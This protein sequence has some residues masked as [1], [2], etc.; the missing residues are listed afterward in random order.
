MEDFN[1][2]KKEE[3]Q[4]NPNEGMP[5]Q[6]KQYQESRYQDQNDNPYY[7]QQ[8]Y[9]YQNQYQP[10]QQPKASNGMSIASMVL[11]IIGIIMFCIPYFAIPAA[12]VGLILG[13]VSIRTHKGGRGMA[14]A[15][16]ILSIIALLFG[17][18][19]V[20]SMFSLFQNPDFFNQFYEEMKGIENNQL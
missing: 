2:K 7:Q 15:G 14:I 13:I 16:L 17:L 3:D 19:I 1:D 11:G 12:I 10:Y 6:Q 20:V 8:Q 18:L 9:Q 4:Q 5:D